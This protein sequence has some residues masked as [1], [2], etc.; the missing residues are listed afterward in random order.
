M[1][2]VLFGATGQLGAELLPRLR[3]LGEV[4]APPRA[5]SPLCGDLEMPQEV[6]R[7]ITDLS[8][9]LVVNAAAMND[10][11]AA[12]TPEGGEKA[13]LANALAPAEMAAACARAGALFVHFST[14]YV[15]GEG[16]G[17][18]DETA[19]PSPLNA[20]GRSKLEGERLIAESGARSLVFRVSWLVSARRRNFLKTI[21]G[22]A[23][24]K[25]SLRAASDQMSVPTAAAFAAQASA[26]L[27][28]RELRCG[29]VRP[30]AP[31]GI[32]H[33]VPAGFATRHSFAQWALREAASLGSPLLARAGD[34]EPAS[35]SDFPSRARR[36]AD[37]RLANA[38]AAALLGG[39]PRWEACA[40]GA[41]A[42]LAARMQ[43]GELR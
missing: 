16:E 37:S 33:L 2:I 25:A 13:R 41:L 1:R 14:D 35:S 17:P 20:Y 11:E 4:A 18:R 40:A 31:G 28:A 27:A 30:A 43:Q 29:D 34:V 9:A 5:G 22:L 21:L 26:A 12:E 19:A 24:R 7:T 36:P 3:E 38:R 32:L 8:P 6:A 39:V 10:V 15:L 42:E 23:A